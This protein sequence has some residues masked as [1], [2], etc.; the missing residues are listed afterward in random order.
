MSRVAPDYFEVYQIPILEGRALTAAD[1]DT[2][3]VMNDVMAKRYFG[4]VSPIGRRFK[5]DAK[6]P[7]LTVVGVARDV[8]TM[9]PSDPIGE[10]M[11][12]YLGYPTTPR[13]YNFLTLSAAVEADPDAALERI[14]RIVWDVDPRLPIG[15]AITMREQVGNAIAR[16]RFVLSLSGAFTICAVLIAAV[17]VYGVSAYWVARRRRELAIR[18]AMGASPER[19]VWTVVGRSLRLALFGTIA[20]LAIAMAGARVMASLLFAT[21]PRDP[22]TLVSI[23]LLLGAIA[24]IA[25]AGPAFRASRVDPMTTLRA[26]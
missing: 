6:Q 23:T 3:I 20:G 24:V 18:M 26:E 12:V 16:P 4:K 1:G 8:K 11:E 14:R 19:L 22:L 21:D 17:G 2:A 13:P 10:G 9:G 7:W 5:L 15:D 25:C